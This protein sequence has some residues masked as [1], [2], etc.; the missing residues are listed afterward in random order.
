MDFHTSLRLLSSFDP[1]KSDVKYTKQQAS[2]IIANATTNLSMEAVEQANSQFEH[3]LD[4]Y[5]KRVLEEDEVEAWGEESREDA[6]KRV[7][8]RFVLRQWVLEELIAEM[9]KDMKT[10]RTKLARVLEVSEEKIAL[11][12]MATHPF[13]EYDGD[14]EEGQI[15]SRLCGLGGREMLGFQ[16]SCSS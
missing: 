10:A 4:I 9:E 2:I 6:M 16:C 15:R 7:N 12:Q 13:E 1:S 8:P 11:M 14:G 3:W 5:A